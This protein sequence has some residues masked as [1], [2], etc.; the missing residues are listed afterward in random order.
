MQIKFSHGYPKLWNQAKAELVAVRILDA[1]E[2]QENQS[3]LEYDT[4]YYAEPSETSELHFVDSDSDYEH[5]HYPLPKTGELI[6]LIFVGDKHIPFCTIRTRYRYNQQT[7]QKEDKFIYY[8]TFI[9]SW[10]DIIIES[11]GDNGK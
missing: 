9:G 4:R 6:Q 11:E 10:L 3:L 1:K 8:S 5:R 2:V 7:K